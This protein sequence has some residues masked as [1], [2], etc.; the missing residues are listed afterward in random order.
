MCILSSIIFLSCSIKSDKSKINE[1]ETNTNLDESDI[2]ITVNTDASLKH[3]YNTIDEFNK[4][5]DVELIIKGIISNVQYTY[6]DGCAYSILSIDILKSYKGNSPKKII[7]YE[8]GGYVKVKDMINEL[9]NHIDT[10]KL[11]QNQIEND[12]VDIKFFNSEHSKIG[13][14]V[15]LYLTP[16]SAPLPTDSYRI[17]S[18]LYG[19]FTLDKT[20]GKYKRIE[21]DG[22]NDKVGSKNV[23]LPN[24]YEQDISE[25]DMSN[26]FKN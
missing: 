19:R 23:G 18:S 15:I 2:L 8:D 26:K 21:L 24:K 7:V 14:Q 11:S 17:I 16:N 25:T 10:S 12:V 20:S 1:N 4:S 22:K 5:N 13:E 3:M 6:I 9:K